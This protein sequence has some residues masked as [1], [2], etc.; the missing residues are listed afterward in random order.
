MWGNSREGDDGV[1]STLILRQWAHG[2]GKHSESSVLSRERFKIGQIRDRRLCCLLG[3][4]RNSNR[5]LYF[6]RVTYSKIKKN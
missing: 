6:L 3:K 2:F 1:V 4:Q 5:G